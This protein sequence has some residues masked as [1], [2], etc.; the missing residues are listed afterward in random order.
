MLNRLEHPQGLVDRTS[1]G[2]VVDGRVLNDTLPVDDEQSTE[3]DSIVR[4]HIIG[5]RDLLLEIGDESVVDVT[6]STLVPR[7]LDPGQVAKLRVD[8]HA[9]HLAVEGL[10]LLIAVGETG[11]LRRADKR[12]VQRIEE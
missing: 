9:Q 12:E 11:D 3:G 7:G 2:E 8:R 6:D 5:G 4:K 1:E 10:K